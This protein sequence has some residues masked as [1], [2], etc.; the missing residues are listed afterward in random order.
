MLWTDLL[1]TWL[2]PQG[3]LG[4]A[5]VIAI[6]A[7]YAIIIFRK[8]IIK[9]I[10]ENSGLA[11]EADMERAIGGLRAEFKT[12]MA[13][14]RKDMEGL[15]TELKGDMAL[16]RKD[17]EILRSDMERNNADLRRDMNDLRRELKGD[18]KSMKGDIKSMK[19]NDLLHI[20]KAILLLAEALQNK[21][22]YERIKDTLEDAP[23]EDAPEE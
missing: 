21:E 23:A 20:K 15:R 17:M 13:F 4:V 12:D 2:T 14:L 6:I 8:G 22:R 7:P 19:G 11:T 5:L 3:A 9:N 1:K 18:I 10:I 16:L